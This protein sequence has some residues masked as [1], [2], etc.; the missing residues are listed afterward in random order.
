MLCAPVGHC[1][2]EELEMTA[3][4]ALGTKFQPANRGN[5]KTG[6]AV[7][8]TKNLR[9]MTKLKSKVQTLNCLSVFGLWTSTYAAGRHSW[10][11]A[12]HVPY[13]GFRD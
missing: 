6:R 5:P 1:E 12:K 10:F 13:L 11:D 7:H 4:R 9:L 3:P 8:Q 2:D